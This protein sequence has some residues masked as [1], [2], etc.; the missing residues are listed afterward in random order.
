MKAHTAIG[1]DMLR[2]LPRYQEE[3]LLQIAIEICRW[4]HERYDGKG[5]PDGL[6][7]DEIPISAQLVSIADV[8]DALISERVYKKAFSHEK[9]MQMIREGECGAFNPLLLSC[10]EEIADEL[11]AEM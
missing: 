4:H 1:A 6:V 9:A 10:L 2:N 3:R 5:Y 8:Y 11:Q 7:G